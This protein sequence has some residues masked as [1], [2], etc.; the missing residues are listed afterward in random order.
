[1]SIVFILITSMVFFLPD[2]IA[3]LRFN[4]CGLLVS[5]ENP[6]HCAGHRIPIGSQ[7]RDWGVNASSVNEVLA[8]EVWGPESNPSTH[9]SL[10][11]V[12]C[13]CNPGWRDRGQTGGSLRPVSLNQQVLRFRRDLVSQTKVE[14]HPGRHSTSISGLHIH[15]VHTA[16][17]THT[18]RKWTSARTCCFSLNNSWAVISAHLHKPYLKQ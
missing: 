9:V 4:G 16:P 3:F 5:I 2:I 8:T 14:S 7:M 15:G 1:M 12:V 18:Q 13:A 17:N 6:G 11:V 10:G